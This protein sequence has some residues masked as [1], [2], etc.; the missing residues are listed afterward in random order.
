MMDKMIAR[1]PGQ[2]EEALDIG[3]ST[4]LK[5]HSE[6]I[7]NVYIAGLGVSGIG[8]NFVAQFVR[9]ECKVP[10]SV[11]KGYSIPASVGKQTLAIASSY[12]GNT[13]ET[14]ASF[15][16]MEKTGAKLIVISSGG[17]LI[18]ISKEKGYDFVLLPDG[19]PSPNACLG[20]SLVQQLCVLYKFGLISDSTIKR[21]ERSASSLR[22]Q[23]E[24]I[25]VQAQE[26]AIRLDKKIPVI[27]TTARMEPVAIRLRQQ[28]NENSKM[29]C[30]HHVIPEM[31][32]NE[33]VGWRDQRN[34]LAVLYLRNDDDFE[35][36]AI[37]IDINREII[38]EY[39]DT[40][41]EV[42][43]QG[44]NVVEKVL[45]L[46]HL[47]DWISWYL[48]VLNGVDCIEKEVIDYLKSELSKIQ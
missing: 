29:L 30:W 24:E 45:Y 23:M 16:L 47:G 25:K 8:A 42:Y 39:A 2:L 11:G 34:E 1:F 20:F 32:H 17:K 35:R 7:E 12:S 4:A 21:V 40:I 19:W 15:A 28:I 18:E 31:N 36:N 48:S 22:N 41:I 13:E 9:G 33:L 38:S 3:R 14:L 46:V 43:S 5:Q 37:R 26:V 27:Y 6:R 10:I 44:E